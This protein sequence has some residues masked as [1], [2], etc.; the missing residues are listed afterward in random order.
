MISVYFLRDYNDFSF[1]D[2]QHD[3]VLTQFILKQLP[4]NLHLTH[5]SR[6]YVSFNSYLLFHLYFKRYSDSFEFP[7]LPHHYFH[8]QPNH[9]NFSFFFAF[10]K[11]VFS[12]A[13]GLIILICSIQVISLNLPSSIIEL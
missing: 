10:T 8:L 3:L 6:F 12:S 4:S 5:C 13:N 1:L 7:R 9:N 11:P 2:E